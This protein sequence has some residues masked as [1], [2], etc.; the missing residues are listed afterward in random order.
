MVPALLRKCRE[1]DTAWVTHS[2]V[3][4]R[5]FWCAVLASTPL[6]APFL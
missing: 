4:V 3:A 1:V 2:L 6:A 5:V